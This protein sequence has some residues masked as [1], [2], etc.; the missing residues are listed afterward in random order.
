MPAGRGWDAQTRQA[1]SEFASGICFRC[2]GGTG[3]LPTMA[4]RPPVSRSV[5]TPLCI[6]GTNSSNRQRGATLCNS[7]MRWGTRKNSK[8]V[9][10]AIR[11]V[12]SDV[13]GSNVSSDSSNSTKPFMSSSTWAETSMPLSVSSIFCPERTSSGSPKM[14]RRRRRIALTD[15]W[16]WPSCAA[17]PETLRSASRRRRMSSSRRLRPKKLERLFIVTADYRHLGVVGVGAFQ[18]DRRRS[19]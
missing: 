12:R 3:Q 18:P 17:T 13:A 5:S 15:G 9:A 7:A 4:S 14:S 19:A 8:D 1:S 6:V 10:A 11:M 2:G 16:L